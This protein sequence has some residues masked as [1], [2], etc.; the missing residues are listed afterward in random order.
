V[1]VD[2]PDMS[3]AAEAQRTLVAMVSHDLRNPL[4]LIKGTA[5]LLRGHAQHSGDGE[6]KELISNLE[7]IERAVGQADRVV[8]DLVDLVQ[9]Q[10]GHSIMLEKAPTDL[11]ALARRAV[12]V[13]CFSTDVHSIFL[14][15]SLESLVGCWDERRLERVLANL[16]SN[17]IKYSPAGRDITV[18]VAEEV[19]AGARWAILTVSDRGLGI[20]RE[21]LDR[22]FEPF[23]RGHGVE[24]VIPGAGIGLAGARHTV[25]EHG[26]SIEVRS[27]LG[28]GAAF[29][30]RL[31][32]GDF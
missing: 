10:T 27:H 16:L 13:H 15:T 24:G 31:P 32:L 7:R 4:F 25:Q 3:P 30:V 1:E 12:D 18:A 26:G 22:I 2:E 5:E 14:R 19:V 21:D 11:V 17:A 20:P 9:L 23:Y 29:I 8:D 6:T 28:Q